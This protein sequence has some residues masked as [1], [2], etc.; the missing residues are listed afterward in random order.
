MVVLTGFRVVRMWIVA[1]T[2]GAAFGVVACGP[3]A[4]ACI[5]SGECV[6]GSAQGTCEASGFCSFADIACPSMRRYGELAGDG[7][8][9]ECVEDVGTT[10]DDTSATTSSTTV[11][12]ETEGPD[13]PYGPCEVTSDCIDPTAVCVTN[14]NNRMC[15]PTC[16]TEG[17]PSSECPAGLD[18]DANGVGCLFTDAE[19]TITR[20]FAVCDATLD[21]PG[22]MICAPPVCTWEGE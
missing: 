18:G 7:L 2:L 10:S 12:I 19:Q 4:F 11:P 17:T 3:G 22:G 6:D 15:A 13:N 1:A 8:G 20:C 21:C 9:G 14:G 5:D 16:T